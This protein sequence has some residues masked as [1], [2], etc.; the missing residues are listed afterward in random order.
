MEKVREVIMMLHE[1]GIVIV[2]VEQN[3]QIA[4]SLCHYIYFMEKGTV[5]HACSA[6]QARSSGVL[7]R[8]LGVHVSAERPTRLQ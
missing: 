6:E 1:Q 7:E 8:F 4:L 2:L 5:V 3:L